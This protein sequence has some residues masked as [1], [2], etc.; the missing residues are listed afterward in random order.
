[1]PIL[2]MESNGNT[3]PLEQAGRKKAS[4]KTAS[5]GPSGAIFAWTCILLRTAG[6]HET[7]HCKKIYMVQ[8][9]RVPFNSPCTE[10]AQYLM[11][12]YSSLSLISQNIHSVTS[13]FCPNLQHIFNFIDR[14]WLCAW[15]LY[16][17]LH[18]LRLPVPLSAAVHLARSHSCKNSIREIATVVLPNRPA[19]IDTGGSCADGVWA[20]PPRGAAARPRPSC[21]GKW[22]LIWYPGFHVSYKI[23]KY[24][25]LT[26]HP[27]MQSIIS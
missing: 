18:D 14:W 11:R 27:N 2:W 6:S 17:A 23:S 3:S 16:L 8:G 21:A 13:V 15:F 7:Q 4:P 22:Y 10:V 19:Y 5:H 12:Y 20:G 26:W 24:L 9:L 1:M 25:S